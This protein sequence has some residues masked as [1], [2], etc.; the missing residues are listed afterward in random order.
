MWKFLKKHFW[1]FLSSIKSVNQLIFLRIV[2]NLNV[3][4][5]KT[6]EMEP[7]LSSVLVFLRVFFI[8]C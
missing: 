6:D 8:I 4:Y 2:E 5:I 7:P 1:L 3:F